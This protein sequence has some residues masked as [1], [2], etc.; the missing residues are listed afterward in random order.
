LETIVGET[1]ITVAIVRELER[2]KLM[3]DRKITPREWA[4]GSGPGPGVV[5]GPG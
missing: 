5:I 4:R 2:R 3:T 1:Q